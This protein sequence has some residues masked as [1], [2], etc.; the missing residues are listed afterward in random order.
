MAPVLTIPKEGLEFAL[1][2]DASKQGLGAVLMQKG[3][4]IKLC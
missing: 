2:Y 4:V 3:K 1:Y